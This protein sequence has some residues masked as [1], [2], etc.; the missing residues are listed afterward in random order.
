ME[1]VVLTVPDCPNAPVLEERLAQ[2]LAEIG[3]HASIVHRTVENAEQAERWG[4]H[5]SPTLLVDGVDPFAIPNEPVSVSCRVQ[6]APSVAALRKVLEP[7]PAPVWS[8]SLGRAGAGRVAPVEGGLR[9]VHQQVLRSF[10]RTGQAPAQAELS[11]KV[12]T[13]LHEADFLRLDQNGDVRAAY[14][15]SATPTTHQV[16]IDGGPRAYAMCAID[17][18]GMAAM[19]G[20]DV[21]VD[22]RDPVTGE[23]ITVT[24]PADGHA[25][26]W[27]P[28]EAVVFAGQ[29]TSCCSSPA[30]DV[31]CGY[32]N[33]F[34][35]RS[36][37]QAWA[38]GHPDVTG[39]ILHQDEALRLG[40]AIFGPLLDNEHGR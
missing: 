12:L 28:Q 5:G 36:I 17:A 19:L 13:Q 15:F 2:A 23:P 35:S 25:A 16:Q 39:Q 9:A 33:F 32:V 1:I 7:K 10:A 24:L 29:Q 18:L 27:N 38:D 21:R 22:S 26:A 40:V 8:D 6:G 30:A 3:A 37:A 4:M 31:C 14:P 20:Q 11:E 34:A